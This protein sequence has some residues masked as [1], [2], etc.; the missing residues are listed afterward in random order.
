MNF[1][2]PSH[3][4]VWAL[5]AVAVIGLVMFFALLMVL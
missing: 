3:A 4:S 2:E 1:D 5:L